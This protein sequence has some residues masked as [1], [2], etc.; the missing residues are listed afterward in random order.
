MG[1]YRQSFTQIFCLEITTDFQKLSS[2]TQKLSKTGLTTF[3]S[4]FWMKL[5]EDTML[6]KVTFGAESERTSRFSE[7]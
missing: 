1:F 3:A 6:A 5:A 7:N 2:I 4:L